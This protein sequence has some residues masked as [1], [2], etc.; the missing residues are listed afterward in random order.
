MSIAGNFWISFWWKQRSQENKKSTHKK[1]L[2]IL[3]SADIRNE[4]DLWRL[5]CLEKY[6]ETSL[7]RE[8]GLLIENSLGATRQM[9]PFLVHN[10]FVA[11]INRYRTEKKFATGLGVSFEDISLRASFY[12]ASHFST[13][14]RARKFAWPLKRHTVLY[15]LRKHSLRNIFFLRLW[16]P[17]ETVL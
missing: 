16:T 4:W 3:K 12:F 15:R 10:F 1:F 14:I 2:L 6:Q 11:P 7:Y 17:F 5:G 9:P 13:E 8:K